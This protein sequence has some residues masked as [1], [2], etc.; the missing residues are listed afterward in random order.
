MSKNFPFKTRDSSKSHP[1]KNVD[2]VAWARSRD[3]TGWRLVLS[4]AG[5]DGRTHQLIVKRSEIIRGDALF[6]LLDDFGFS[7]PSDHRARAML[8][9]RLSTLT[10][11]LGAG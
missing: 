2:A 10:L 6:E 8:R 7:V 4:F 11:K 9:H 5:R 1:Q 3:G